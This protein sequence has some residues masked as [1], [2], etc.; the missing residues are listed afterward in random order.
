VQVAVSTHPVFE[1]H[2]LINS[3]STQQSIDT[4]KHTSTEARENM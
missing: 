3:L 4:A 2:T 1:F